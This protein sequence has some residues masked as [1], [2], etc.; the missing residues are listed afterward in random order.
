[1]RLVSLVAIVLLAGCTGS[2]SPPKQP[3]GNNVPT[4]PTSFAPIAQSTLAALSFTLDPSKPRMSVDFVVPEGVTQA[5]LN[6]TLHGGAAIRFSA[7]TTGCTLVLNGPAPADGNTYGQD[8][9]A[10][11]PGNATLVVDQSAGPV[12]GVADLTARLCLKRPN[13]MCA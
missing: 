9:G 8:C 1:M 7:S 6:V 3:P 10:M 11:T 2:D 5:L 4:P 12:S 13:T